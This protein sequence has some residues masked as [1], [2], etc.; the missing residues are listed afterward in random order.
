[1]KSPQFHHYKATI[2][3]AIRAA[4]KEAQPGVLDEAAFPAYSHPNPLINWVFWERLRIVMDFVEKR[5]PFEHILDFGCGSG[6]LLPFLADHSRS[7]LGID[8]DLLPFE[9][10]RGRIDFP[11]NVEVRDTRSSPIAQVASGSFDLITAL[12]VLEH[13]EDLPTTLEKLMRSL[14]PNG[15]L[16]VSGPTE[17]VF[18]KIGRHLAGPEYSGAY[19]ERGIAEVRKQLAQLAPVTTI[20][21]LFPPIV[22]FDIFAAQAR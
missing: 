17:S 1:M 3:T 5:A 19:H 20:A 10:M 8:T 14:K 11:S 22:L 6:V 4:L 12:D 15:W 21:R 2:R 7:V 13:V 18:Y 9:L 16:I